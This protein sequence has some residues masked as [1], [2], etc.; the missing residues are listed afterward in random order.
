MLEFTRIPHKI[1][2]ISAG[3]RDGILR[4]PGAAIISGNLIFCIWDAESITRLR[5]K[6]H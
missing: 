5:S 2:M 4:K 1:E 3:G 6:G